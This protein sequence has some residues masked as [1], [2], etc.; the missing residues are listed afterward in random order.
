MGEFNI[1]DTIKMYN[2]FKDKYLSIINQVEIEKICY[3]LCDKNK[4]K[5]KQFHNDNL[6]KIEILSN[7]F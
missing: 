2:L 7:V 5:I 4:S 3:N 1:K 6:D